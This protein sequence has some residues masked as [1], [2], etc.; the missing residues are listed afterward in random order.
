MAAESGRNNRAKLRTRISCLAVAILFSSAGDQC[1]G[2][3]PGFGVFLSQV[4]GASQPKLVYLKPGTR[5]GSKPPTGWSHM[6]I[7]SLPRLSS[8]DRGTLPS[9]ASKTATLFRTVIMANVL[10]L[11]TDEKD[12]IL[13]QVGLGI[14]IPDDEGHDIVV[15]GDRADA[16][17]LRL[18][19]VQKAVL[20]AAEAELA[21]GRIIARTS[22][23]ALFRTPTTVLEDGKHRR[24]DLFYAF[25]A[26]R[27]TGKLRVAAWT[28]PA[29]ALKHQFPPSLVKLGP[30]PVYNCDLDVRAKRVLGTVPYSWSFA[31]IA[32]P[33][34]KA[35]EV[36]AELG[37]MITTTARKPTAEH[38]E[39]L[40]RLMTETLA[41]SPDKTERVGLR[42][43]APPR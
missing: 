40:E 21:E 29:N 7:K 27:T 32:L 11:D 14:C 39:E 15:S 8:G 35:L 2:S 42:I 9:G 18:S 30:N 16:L 38:A 13:Q 25:C 31:M 3:S 41:A 37:E 26:D 43:T 19:L 17:G 36:P 34:G 23:F 4:V 33:P 24:L 5:I 12:F 10:A 20:D 28:M 22:T 6:V 1:A